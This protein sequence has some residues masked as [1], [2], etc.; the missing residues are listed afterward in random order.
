M[1]RIR[2][3]GL[4]LVAVFAMSSLLAASASAA[5]PEFSG[6][7]PKADTAKSGKL[8][9]ETVGKI[10]ANCTASTQTGEVLGPKTGT[11]TIRSTGCEAVGFKCNTAGAATGEIVTSGLGVTLGYINQA[12]KEVGLALASPPSGAP[13]A[14]ITCGPFTVVEIGSVI[15]V[16]KPINKTVK[17][18]KHFTVTFKQSKGKQKPSK[19]EGGPVDVLESSANGLPFEE[20][21]LSLKGE[22]KFGEAVEIK[23]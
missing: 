12:K 5:L 18:S 2:M 22:L 14:E 21:G 19:F 23:A 9:L 15:G 6:P 16:I 20:E 3:I 11:V 7:F 8:H 13:F 1:K 10:A 17:V 4:C